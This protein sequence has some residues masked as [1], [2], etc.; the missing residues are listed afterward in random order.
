[1]APYLY[2]NLDTEHEIVNEEIY[3]IG[4]ADLVKR[5]DRRKKNYGI[6]YEG[7]SG[8]ENR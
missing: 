1:M 2:K 7:N 4:E 5:R 3:V 6:D 8:G